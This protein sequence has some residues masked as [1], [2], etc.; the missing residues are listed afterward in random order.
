VKNNVLI[1]D[2]H[3]AVRMGVRLI[4]E[5]EG[6]TVIGE[7]DDGAEAIKQIAQLNPALIVLDIG[8]PQVNGL[9]ILDWLSESLSTVKIIILTAQHTE[10]LALR[11][12]QMGA[13]GFVNKNS[14]LCQLANAVRAVR[15][16]YSYFPEEALSAL[17][18]YTRNGH[19]D[20]LDSLSNRELQVLQKLTQGLSNKQ[21][22]ARMLLSDKTISTY[23]T[24][25]LFKLKASSLW[26]L[27]QLAKRNGIA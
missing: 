3:P 12:L 1:I 16:G 8:L 15:S 26:D 23:K 20:S 5:S 19:P 21:I 2:D 24:R 27:Y 4:L 6:C 25:I 17:R 18:K 13:H 14:D 10:P 11:C 7:V 22:A 9:A